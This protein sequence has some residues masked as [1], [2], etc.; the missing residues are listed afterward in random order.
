MF[1]INTDSILLLQRFF[2]GIFF[3]I[4]VWIFGDESLFDV[5]KIGIPASLVLAFITVYFF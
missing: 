2:H 1:E 5:L 3:C 4:M